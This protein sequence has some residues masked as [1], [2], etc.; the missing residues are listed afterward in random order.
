MIS[1]ERR[2]RTAA[3]AAGACCVAAIACATPMVDAGAPPY[4]PTSLTAGTLY[5]WPVGRTL[6]V[7]VAS[8]G[9]SLLLEESV[10]AALP[11]WTAALAFRE[12]TFRIVDRADRADILVRDA[13][14]PI[15]VDSAGCGSIRW[16][17]SAASTFFCPAGDTAR[18]L[19]LVA[20]PPGRAKVLIT[21]N[22]AGAPDPA[23][24]LA[25][26]VHE[27][28]HALGIGGHSADPADVM[29]AAPVIPAPSAADARTLRYVLHRRPHL[30]L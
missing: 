1:V 13:A 18:T 27:I 9:A 19:P 15:P 24:R 3:L 7:H 20:G 8:G 29:H 14:A 6:D 12:H 30:T 17:E 4:D 10:R 21:V 22:M 23:A 2:V 26:V 5:H 25:L 28:G 11:R 16:T